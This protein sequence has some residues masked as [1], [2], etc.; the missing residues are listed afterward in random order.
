MHTLRQSDQRP[1]WG[2]H[3]NPEEIKAAFYEHFDK[4]VPTWNGRPVMIES[5]AGGLTLIAFWVRDD[6]I[7]EQKHN[8]KQDQNT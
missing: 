7:V 5:K 2:E 3:M 4:P 8:F 1:A 6:Q